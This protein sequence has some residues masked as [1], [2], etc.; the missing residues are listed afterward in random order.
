MAN[1]RMNKDF[2]SWW[3]TSW[4]GRRF[5]D[6][7]P[8]I[9]DGYAEVAALAWRAGMEFGLKS[10]RTP[11]QQQLRAAAVNTIAELQAWSR[12]QEGRAEE[13]ADG[14][15]EYG[16]LLFDKHEMLGMSRDTKALADELLLSLGE[17]SPSEH[18][19]LD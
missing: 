14:S 16:Q 2:A 15:A 7:P 6:L 17:L 18:A 12:S 9:K 5:A 19:F 1:L 8:C 3:A 13:A 11:D 10:T 4:I